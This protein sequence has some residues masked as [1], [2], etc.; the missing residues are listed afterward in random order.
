MDQFEE[1]ASKEEFAISLFQSREK[2]IIDLNDTVLP[3][4]ICDEP[5]YISY[6]CILLPGILSHQLKTEMEGPLLQRMKEIC[7]SFNGRIEFITVNPDYF[8][9][10]L[11]VIS[12]AQI[13]QI[14]QEIRYGLSQMILSTFEY[15]RSENSAD[16]FWATGYLVLLGMR[17]DL[18]DMIKQYIRISR[19]L[20]NFSLPDLQDLHA[21]T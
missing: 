11:S 8:Q 20:Q 14:M 4:A 9:W 19:R 13:S 1:H 18:E 6:T 2:T 21:R 17:P 5:D 15:I 3:V 12:S 7:T 10:G 16:D